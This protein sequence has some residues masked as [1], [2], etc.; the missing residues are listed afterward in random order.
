MKEIME[1]ENS[2]AIKNELESRMGKRNGW[3]RKSLVLIIAI[4]LSIYSTACA[5]GDFL[6]DNSKQT[7]AIAEEKPSYNF[8]YSSLTEPQILETGQPTIYTMQYTNSCDDAV[9]AGSKLYFTT[10]STGVLYYTQKVEDTW[11]VK[12]TG[13]VDATELEASGSCLYALIRNDKNGKYSLIIYNTDKDIQV[14]EI[15]LNKNSTGN[16]DSRYFY[17]SSA[18]QNGVY[19]YGLS[20]AARSSGSQ[21]YTAFFKVDPDGEISEL[22]GF[23]SKDYVQLTLVKDNTFYYDWNDQNGHYG[24]YLLNKDTNKT[25]L[26]S[27]QHSLGNESLVDYY[28]WN[29]QLVF[30][31]YE[32]G[33]CIA[34]LDGEKE[35]TYEF[36]S[37][38]SYTVVGDFAYFSGDSLK[39]VDLK[40]G[41]VTSTGQE[42]EKYLGELSVFDGKLILLR[43]EGYS[44][45][46]VQP[47]MITIY[48]LDVN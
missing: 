29:N 36:D 6:K 5:S 23:D 7:L 27:K 31:I 38:S 40:T 4:L 33:L 39:K 35:K 37:D 24:V 34:S 18:D 17:L 42:L 10:G 44:P 43:Y 25:I 20:N 8:A 11:E 12:N 3:L 47:A 28:I 48:I 32:K 19:F 2:K 22:K 1:K 30:P 13:I 9:G 45:V 16:D 46:Y 26:I 21:D 15:D 41:N 14:N